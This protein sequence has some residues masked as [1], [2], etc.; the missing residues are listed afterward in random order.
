M[1]G[2]PTSSLLTVPERGLV[3][4]VL[5][6]LPYAKTS[7]LAKRLAEAFADTKGAAVR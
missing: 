1:L 6:N 3:I 5:S 4:A 2:G 7:A